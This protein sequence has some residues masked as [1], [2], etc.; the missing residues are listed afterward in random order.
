M[1]SI[2]ISIKD[3]NYDKINQYI[4]Q[5][6]DFEQKHQ[7]KIATKNNFAADLSFDNFFNNSVQAI[8]NK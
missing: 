5:N 3:E 4:D 2:K 8:N 6:I 7:P 1:N